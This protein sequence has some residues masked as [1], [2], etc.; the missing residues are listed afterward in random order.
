MSEHAFSPVD[1]LRLPEHLLTTATPAEAALRLLGLSNEDIRGRRV[2]DL[3]SGASPLVEA[4]LTLGAS[5]AYGVDLIYNPSE[6]TES[7][8]DG[9]RAE[10]SE[11]IPRLVNSVDMA[12]RR[13]RAESAALE[14]FAQSY[15]SDR[16]R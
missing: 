15:R 12:Q 2:V 4:L 8:L 9:I 6:E 13:M 7:L 16:S 1:P 5:G 3:M 14:V 11:S 10:L